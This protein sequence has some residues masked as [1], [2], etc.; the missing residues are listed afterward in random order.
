M[1]F[2][3]EEATDKIVQERYLN[4]RVIRYKEGRVIMP[5]VELINHGHRTE[6][7][8][9]DGISIAGQFDDEILV[10][11]CKQDSFGL[12]RGWGFASEEPWA[13][14]LPMTMATNLGRLVVQAQ[15]DKGRPV[16]FPS[17][18]TMRVPELTQENGQAILSYLTIGDSRFPRTPKS[19]FYRIFE[20]AGLEEAEEKFETIRH[21]NSL[22]FL[23]LIEALEDVKSPMV[24]PLREMAR[25]QLQ[26]IAHCFGTRQL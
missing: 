18:G 25:F 10:A 20:E 6:Y 3:L 14:S 13:Q 21:Y 24:R 4:S 9:D 17:F 22:A 5:L 11:Y 16:K 2:C 1:R 12:F 8:L 26:A 19:I 15:H 23:Q 7:N